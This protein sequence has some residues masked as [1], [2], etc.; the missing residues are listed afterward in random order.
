MILGM[1][2]ATFTVFHV[3]LSLIG[4]AAGIIVVLAIF[5]ALFVGAVRSFRPR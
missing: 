5:V 4:I 3:A 2:L 1:S